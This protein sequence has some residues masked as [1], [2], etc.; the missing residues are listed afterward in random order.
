VPPKHVGFHYLFSVLCALA[1]HTVQGMQLLAE[2]GNVS[3]AW[4]YPAGFNKG[5]VRS[6][7]LPTSVAISRSTHA[8]SRSYL[9]WRNPHYT[10]NPVKRSY[11]LTLWARNGTQPVELA[12]SQI[13]RDLALR[14]STH[15]SK[16][17]KGGAASLGLASQ[18]RPQSYFRV[19][20]LLLRGHV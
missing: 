18:P 19:Q 8:R 10:Q 12:A 2:R 3:K 13:S 5:H 9:G 4:L 15:P 17:A 16:T 20:L 7:R 6:S 11:P 1:L 14:R